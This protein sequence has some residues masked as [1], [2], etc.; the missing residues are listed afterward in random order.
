MDYILGSKSV[1]LRSEQT[2]GS[3]AKIKVRVDPIPN[4]T[5]AGFRKKGVDQ[6]SAD[7]SIR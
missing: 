7:F 5:T 6:E 4:F 2:L 3:G 1:S